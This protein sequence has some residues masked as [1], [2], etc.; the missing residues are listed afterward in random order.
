MNFTQGHIQRTLFSDFLRPFSLMV[1]GTA[2]CD[3]ISSLGAQVCCSVALPMFLRLY[4]STETYSFTQH[5]VGSD[6]EMIFITVTNCHKSNTP[7]PA[8][9]L[10][11]SRASNSLARAA[12]TLH[13]LPHRTH[14]AP[15]TFKRVQQHRTKRFCPSQQQQRRSMMTCDS[16]E[17]HTTS[18]TPV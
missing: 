12:R 10:P 16:L 15:N 5:H 4:V 13:Q 8:L 2:I 9:P 1:R 14:I 17:S 11:R 3:V 6:V 7:P 18:V